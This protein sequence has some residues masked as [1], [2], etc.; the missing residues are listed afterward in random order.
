MKIYTIQGIDKID[1]DFSVTTLKRG[2]FANKEKALER[3]KEE[4][5]KLKNTFADE[6]AEYSN[7]EEYSDVDEGAL[8]MLEY[9]ESGFYRISFG[10]EED[11]ETHTIEVEE[12]DVDSELRDDLLVTAGSRIAYMSVSNTLI[13][14]EGTDGERE[15][16][17]VVAKAVDDY[18]DNNVDESYDLFIENVIDKKYGIEVWK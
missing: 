11:F 2:C 12:W 1:Y 3:A 17:L 16:S 4:F 13:L 8:E 18:I 10:F 5:E 6:I 9:P 14:P 7:E 15:I